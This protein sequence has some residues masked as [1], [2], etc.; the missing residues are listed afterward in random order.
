MHVVRGSFFVGL[1]NLAV[2][3]AQILLALALFKPVRSIV[4]PS[5]AKKLSDALKA[6]NKVAA[7]HIY[8]KRRG[9]Q[10]LAAEA[11][12]PATPFR[13]QAEFGD[14][15]IFK[16]GIAFMP[17]ILE[18]LGVKAGLWRCR[19]RRAAWLFDTFS[20]RGV[21][22]SRSQSCPPQDAR[23]LDGKQLE[24]AQHVVGMHCDH[25]FPNII[26]DGCGVTDHHVKAAGGAWTIGRL[27]G[28]R[29]P[30]GPI[31]RRFL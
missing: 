1:L 10:T 19:V 8:G 27:T 16:A 20:C 11:F 7:Q 9:G 18:V 2:P 23:G 12:Q 4:V 6:G 26:L 3:A 24:I 30:F 5:L 25:D 15:S 29:H 28:V 17:F 21:V 13:L 22:F 31:Q 14:E